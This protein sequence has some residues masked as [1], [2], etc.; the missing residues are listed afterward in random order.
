[1]PWPLIG[2]QI[3]TTWVCDLIWG[4]IKMG[5]SQLGGLVPLRDALALEKE[6][7]LW[8]LAAGTEKEVNIVNGGGG[9]A[10]QRRRKG[11]RMC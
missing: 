6:G 7:E 4:S 9:T 3:F 5:F 1:M 10:A 8:P 11:T 2:T